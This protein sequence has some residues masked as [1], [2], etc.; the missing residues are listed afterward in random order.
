MP[1]PPNIAI[2]GA[3]P[4]GCTLARLLLNASIPVTIYESD[5]SLTTRQ[6]GGTL[7][8]H[9]PSGQLALKKCG[10]YEEFVKYARYDGEALAVLDK[11]CVAYIK[12]GGADAK[13]SRGRPE[14][15]RPQLREILVNSLP[16]GTIRW[17]TKVRA[18]KEGEGKKGG[19]EIHLGDGAVERGYDLIVGADGAWSKVRP[20]LSDAKPY[21]VGLG[22]IG[23]NIYN[24]EK[25]VPELYKLANRG[26][27]FSSS[28]GRG[29]SVQ[30][31]G[32][33]SLNM[34]A[35]SVRDEDWMEKCGYDVHNPKEMKE[36]MRKEFADWKEPLYSAVEKADE[37]QIVARSLYQL[38]SDH[39][40]EA[41]RG[42]T[43]I[44]DAAH[45]MT[46]FAGEGV[47]MAMTDAMELADAII[48]SKRTGNWEQVMPGKVRSFELRMFKRAAPISE[49]SRQQMLSLFFTEGAPRSIIDVWIRRALGG[50]H[51]DAWW[52]KLIA[53]LWLIRFLL[54]MFFKW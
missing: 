6:Q 20:V 42:V 7:D 26:S 2:V 15:D 50:P 37:P 4:S 16:E 30:Q 23:S 28:D 29:L 33:G 18:V 48:E 14:I 36:M 43:L 22:G 47:N 21:F 49:L 44:G 38:P 41:K 35:W 10:L 32:D 39:R 25:E 40:W 31:M 5:A 17:G 9:V 12:I 34:Y 54:R 46:P 45:V 1:P 53:P 8:L 19:M 3:G 52:L 13:S 24:A 51:F 27:I 11:K